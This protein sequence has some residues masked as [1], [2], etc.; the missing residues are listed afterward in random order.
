ME[1]IYQDEILINEIGTHLVYV[2]VI[3]NYGYVTYANTDYIV[4]DGYAGENIIIGRNASTYEEL[5]LYY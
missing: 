5:A 2:R 4:L 3:D 1:N